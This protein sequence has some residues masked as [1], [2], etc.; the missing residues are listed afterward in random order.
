MGTQETPLNM[1]SQLRSSLHRVYENQVASSRTLSGLPE[2]SGS[3]SHSF[4]E[5]KQTVISFCST[6]S[7]AYERQLSSDGIA[8][9]DIVMFL[10]S[11][12]SEHELVDELDEERDQAVD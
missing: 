7:K 9:A 6:L 1:L 10:P 2:F 8:L 3:N 12:F 5:W 11:W 4:R